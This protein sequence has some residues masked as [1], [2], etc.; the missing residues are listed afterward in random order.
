MKTIRAI[1]YDIAPSKKAGFSAVAVLAALLAVSCSKSEQAGA[2]RK[3]GPAPVRVAKAVTTDVPNQIEAV[4]NIEAFS[5][6]S[7]TSQVNGQIEK[8]HFKEGDFVK[9]GDLLVTIDP[10]PFRAALAQAVA[11]KER[12]VVQMKNAQ[13]E[14]ARNKELV[15][16]GYISRSQYDQLAA[17]ADG[18][19]AAVAADKAAEETAKLN[20]E[21]CFIRAPFAGKTGAVMIYPGN[22]V[23]AND[24][25]IV[26]V[27]QIKPVYADFALPQQNLA[28]VKKYLSEGKLET[29][30]LQSD[31]VP[32]VKGDLKFID[33][34]VD[35]A[36]GTIKLK[37]VFENGDKSLWPG[38]FVKVSLFL[39]TDKGV[40][41]VPTPA[42]INT[43]KGSSVFVV[44]SDD[45][46]ELRPVKTGRSFG[47]ATVVENGL[48]A[49]ETVVTDGQLQTMP[50][51]KVKVIEDQ[52]PK[53]ETGK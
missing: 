13:K 19:V 53:K 43:Q 28:A 17:T 50:G 38:Q 9:E 29:S 37:A 24:K 25:T 30:V 4:G 44:R 15:D 5:T 10:R 16:K 26:T 31:G 1:I 46:A 7:L 48:S 20:L 34:T 32:P 41:V 22:Y 35:P 36:T 42:L 2:Q 45:T 27:L 47:N 51:G 52:P 14:A 8:I 6:L 33:N 11:V 39:T 40:V 49:G 23:K 3:F 18:L 12:D 21:Y